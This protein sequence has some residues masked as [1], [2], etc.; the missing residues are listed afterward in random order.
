MRPAKVYKS[1]DLMTYISGPLTSDFGHIIKVK[2]FAQGRIL[3]STDG[4]KT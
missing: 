3:S 4:S 1:H 2:I